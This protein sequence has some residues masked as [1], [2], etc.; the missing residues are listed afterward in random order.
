MAVLTLD[1]MSK[2]RRQR[3]RNNDNAHNPSS[4]PT[5]KTD[6]PTS[7]SHPRDKDLLHVDHSRRHHHHPGR[8]GSRGGTTTAVA[9]RK[10]SRESVTV[11]VAAVGNVFVSATLLSLLC[12]ACLAAPAAGLVIEE[13]FHHTFDHV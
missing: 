6:Q 1:S 2:L 9:V 10:R 8:N 4:A 3:H 11:A 13:P 7:S 5:S 12:L